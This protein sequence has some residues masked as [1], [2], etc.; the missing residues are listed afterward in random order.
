[1]RNPNADVQEAAALD[2]VIKVL[3]ALRH[4]GQVPFS[5]EASTELD[6]AKQMME[7][8]RAS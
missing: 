8:A 6:Y 3:D 5:E 2:S 1:M 7:D 4:E